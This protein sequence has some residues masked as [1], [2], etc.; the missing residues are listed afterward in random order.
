MK[1]RYYLWCILI[2]GIAGC[3]IYAHQSEKAFPSASI[4]LKLSKTQIEL[5]ADHWR[6]IAGYKEKTGIKSTTFAFDDDAKT[7]LEYEL[8]SSKANQLMRSSIPIWYWSTRY[9]KP[10]KQ[11]EFTCWLDPSGKLVS[12]DHEVQNDL[13][14]PSVSHAQA[15][16]MAQ[17]SLTSEIGIN[18]DNYKLVENS[19]VKQ[20]NRTDHY[21]TFENKAESFHGA[22]LRAYAY[23]SGNVVTEVNHYLR[24]PDAWKRKFS[25]LRSYNDALADIASIFYEAL[26]T[27]V[28]FVFLWALASGRVRWRFSFLA[29]S[30][31]ALFSMLESIN[32][33]PSSIHEYTTT[34]PYG[35][36]QIDFYS[37]ALWSGVSTFFQIFF[38]VAAAEA[39]YRISTP[40]KIL[41]EKLFS[42]RGL[43]TRQGLESVIAGLGTFGVHLGWLI[44]YYI[45]GRA[46]GLWCP[47]EVQNVETLS[48]SVPAFSAINVGWYAGLTEEL[49][50]RVLGLAVF[51]RLT[52][53]FWLA[54]LLQAMAWAFMHSNYPQ[55]PP[56]ARGL[57]LTVVG[58]VY[59][60]I[61]KRFGLL[62]CF[63]S[64]NL[65]DSFLGLAPLFASRDPGL[66][67]SAIVSVLPFLFIA[68]VPIY[69]RWKRKAFLPANE[70]LNSHFAAAHP[71]S[72]IAEPNVIPPAYIYKPLGNF[73]R[74]TLGI[75]IVIVSLI[76]FGIHIHAIGSRSQVTFTREE[77]IKKAQAVLIANNLRPDNYMQVAW[78]EGGLNPEEFQYIHEKEPKKIP[79]LTRSPESPLIWN[80]RFF[81]PLTADLYSVTFDSNGK[82]IA[83]ALSKQEDESG[84]NLTKVQATQLV[85]QYFKK[86]HPELLPYVVE[87]VTEQHREQRTDWSITLAIPKFKVADADYK[88]TMHCLGDQPCGFDNKWILPNQW[89]FKNRI[90]SLREEIC[91]TIIYGLEICFA[92]VA[93]WW[94]RGVIGAAPIPWKAAIILG[95]ALAAVRVGHILNESPLFFRLYD[96]DAPLETYFI[97][98]MVSNFGIVIS[99]FSLFTILAAFGLA[100]VRLLMPHAAVNA[101]LKLSLA[102]Q[103]GEEAAVNRQ[104]WLDAIFIG[105]AAGI[106]CTAL[107]ILSEA[108]RYRISPSI[109]VSPLNS[110]AYFSNV[111][112][113]GIAIILNALAQGITWVFTVSILVG[114]GAK[115]IRNFRSYALLSIFISLV[116]P[117][118]LRYWQDYAVT[119]GQYL[120]FFLATWF[121]ITRLARENLAAYFLIGAIS[122]LVSSLCLLAAHSRSLYPDDLISA[123]VVLLAPLGY[124]IFARFNTRNV[125]VQ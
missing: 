31:Y 6:Q 48:S 98:Q 27:G 72:I 29:A 90:Q 111:S 57:E 67:I 19:S 36:F 42:W 88:I 125:P 107:Q 93:L 81:K 80:V 103:R 79:Q 16:A 47:L 74:S 59:G 122:S 84:A 96:T 45:S 9:C 44:I 13:P 4:D 30:L 106:G 17:N 46:F 71:V 34:T 50:Y 101:I 95:A 76:Q 10:L 110:I 24:V 108:L 32:S 82:L 38:L 66:K 43:S 120:I 14:L 23:V 87:D 2:L 102:P 123:A 85:E 5:I 26:N 86:L 109:V 69:L 39:I 53:N 92:I 60:A 65:M 97:E 115:Y 119:A 112:D 118:A 117:S 78:L 37:R 7:F 52:K 114:I 113:P 73:A 94:A 121:V 77:A 35:A 51:Q 63:L 20:E 22:K 99:Q 8:G 62:A 104:I 58:I 75:I 41:F 21:F 61:F 83:F 91:T 3:F 28:F 40:R 15:L 54:N 12:Y 70:L 68:A 100:S 49:M 25:K 64:H 55:E 105:Y 116:L 89:L 124:V 18:L 56:Y 11:E 1:S 33:L